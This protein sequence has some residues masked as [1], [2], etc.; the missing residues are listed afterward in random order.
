MPL[1]PVLSRELRSL[2]EELAASRRERPM[3]STSGPADSVAETGADRDAA[4]M[5]DALAGGPKDSPAAR[6]LGSQ[7]QDLVKEITDF[8]D[9]AEENISAHPAMSIVAALLL[10]IAIGSLVARR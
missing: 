1:D 2:R 6:E 7:L 5:G 10:G 4:G 8:V 3:Q 9:E